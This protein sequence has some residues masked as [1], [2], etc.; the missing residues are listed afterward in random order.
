MQNILNNKGWFA[1]SRLITHLDTLIANPSNNDA[2]DKIQKLEQEYFNRIRGDWRRWSL[3]PRSK[4]SYAMARN[5]LQ[6]YGKRVSQHKNLERF[7]PLPT[8]TIG[9]VDQPSTT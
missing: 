2:L 6:L 3:K 8:G 7:D 5:V 1:D 9:K 4:S